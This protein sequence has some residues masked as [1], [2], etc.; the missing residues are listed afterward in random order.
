MEYSLVELDGLKFVKIDNGILLIDTG[1]PFSYFKNEKISIND[2]EYKNSFFKKLLKLRMEELSSHLKDSLDCEIIGII[3]MDIISSLGITINRK[4]KTVAFE[5]K[6]IKDAS[7]F[8]FNLKSINNQKY[9]IFDSIDVLG[10]TSEGLHPFIMDMGTTASVFKQEISNHAQY[11]YRKDYYYPSLGRTLT[12]D[13]MFFTLTNGAAIKIVAGG[14]NDFD[15]DSQFEFLGVDG[16]LC[17]NDF[18]WDILSINMD[19]KRIYWK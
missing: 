13:F 14:N 5:A 7:F 2:E 4:E 17:F 9:I 12:S 3:G 10:M 19:K 6:E 15:I 8:E 1:S 11:A 16:E 18:T